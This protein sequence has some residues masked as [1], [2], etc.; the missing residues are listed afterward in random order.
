MLTASARSAIWLKK[1]L[2]IVYISLPYK[3]TT[4]T[5]S[6]IKSVKI[7]ALATYI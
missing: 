7:M 5:T 3:M 2:Q 4:R 1:M 6:I